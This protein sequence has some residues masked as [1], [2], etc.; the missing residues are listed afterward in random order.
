LRTSPGGSTAA[1]LLG[2]S[3][4]RTDLAA[5]LSTDRLP[6]GSGIYT[7]VVGRRTTTA[8]DYRV[9]VRLQST[10]AVS[11]TL[12]RVATNGTETRFTNE[13][14]VTGVSLPV[15]TQLRVRLQVTGTSPTTL[16]ARAWRAGT[17]EPTTWTVTA[18]DSTAGLQTTGAVGVTTYLSSAAPTAVV[19]SV[20]DVVATK[21]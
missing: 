13:T 15:G 16:R 14:T 1:F 20:D 5:T 4:N 2:T 3:S 18:T 21:L 6:G 11:L 17:T 19:V 7:G 9:V 10:G 8:G 12:E